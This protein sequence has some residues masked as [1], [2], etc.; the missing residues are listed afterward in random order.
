MLNFP[1]VG[2]PELGLSGE[3][4]MYLALYFDLYYQ[5]P[6]WQVPHYPL[7]A[8]DNNL[9][10]AVLHVKEAGMK[11][12]PL[13]PFDGAVTVQIIDDHHL[14]ISHPTRYFFETNTEKLFSLNRTFVKGETFHLPDVTI[15]PEEM[16]GNRVKS[17]VVAFVEPLDNPLYYF[18]FY[19][20]GTWQRWYPL[21]DVDIFTNR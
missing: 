14:R 6:E 2:M 16:E 11:V 9:S 12:Y 19:D 8:F 21:K 15:T 5:Y 1:A 18:L 3:N 20:K 4:Y 7:S 10:A 13:S 17:I